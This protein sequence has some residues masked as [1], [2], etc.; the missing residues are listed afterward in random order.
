MLVPSSAD[1]RLLGALRKTVSP[2]GGGGGGGV[3]EWMKRICP[4]YTPS[5]IALAEGARETVSLRVSFQLVFFYLFIF[6]FKQETV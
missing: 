4:C 6:L 3:E 5:R 1:P 2:P